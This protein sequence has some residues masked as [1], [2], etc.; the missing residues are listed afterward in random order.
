MNFGYQLKYNVSHR[1]TAC[2]DIVPKS[3]GNGDYICRQRYDAGM[4]THPHATQLS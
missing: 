2:V 3:V 4:A 1:I